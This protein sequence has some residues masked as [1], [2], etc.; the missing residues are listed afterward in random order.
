M[1]AADS[2]DT[3]R[4][5]TGLD[6]V[7]RDSRPLFEMEYACPD[8]DEPRWFSISVVPLKGSQHGAVITHTDISDRKR[9]EAVTLQLR[10]ELA[11]AGRVM[12]MGML[13]ASLTHELSQPLSAILA[14]GQVARRLCE[15]AMHN[16]APE[17]QEILNDILRVEPARGRDPATAPT[18]V[19][20][21]AVESP[22]FNQSQ[23]RCTGRPAVDA[24]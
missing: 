11:Q 2:P 14:N 7:L 17:L 3:T 6:T 21:R 1:A 16:S 12:T 13:S 10:E 20:R 9:N 19:C 5:L 15:R 8:T 22:R 18:G 23:R 24:Q 4:M